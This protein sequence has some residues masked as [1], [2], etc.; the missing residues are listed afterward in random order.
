MAFYNKA[1]NANGSSKTVWATTVD[2]E[3]VVHSFTIQNTTSTD[4]YFDLLV[5]D[6]EVLQR[7]K[8]VAGSL[9]TMEKP[10]NLAPNSSMK[11]VGD[12]GLKCLFSVLE[13]AVDA[14]AALTEVQSIMQTTEGYKN[15]VLAAAA[16]AASQVASTLPVGSVMDSIINP[17]TTWSSFKINMQIAN[18]AYIDG[19]AA[20]SDYETTIDGGMANG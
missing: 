4:K 18:G 2:R 7:V 11:L 12:N 9:F 16:Q 3:A 6:V 1:F 13:S 20:S 14:A 10:L 15:E 17:N 8:V 5:N 19:G